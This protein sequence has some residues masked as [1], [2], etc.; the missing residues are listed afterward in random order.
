MIVTVER[1]K[2]DSRMCLDW[3]LKVIRLTVESD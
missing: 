3:L 2:I 1:D